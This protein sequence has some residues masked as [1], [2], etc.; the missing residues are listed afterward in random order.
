MAKPA[1]RGVH[2]TMT[3]A[4]DREEVHLSV[5][6]SDIVMG[7]GKNTNEDER[8]TMD[9]VRVRV[10]LQQA[11]RRINRKQVVRLVAVCLAL[12]CLGPSGIVFPTPLL[13]PRHKVV[14]VPT[15]QSVTAMI[16]SL[17]RPRVVQGLSEMNDG[18]R[19]YL[20]RNWKR[21]TAT[22]SR[23]DVS[24]GFFPPQPAVVFVQTPEAVAEHADEHAN[25]KDAHLGVLSIDTLRGL[26]AVNNERADLWAIA[27]KSAE[28]LSAFLREFCWY[29]RTTLVAFGRATETVLAAAFPKDSK[30]RFPTFCTGLMFVAPELEENDKL[31]VSEGAT[32]PPAVVVNQRGSGA[33]EHLKE[34]FGTRLQET[35]LQVSVDSSEFVKVLDQLVQQKSDSV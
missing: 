21:P 22:R 25:K 11:L 15:Y 35:G 18:N 30:D 8:K 17:R 14:T 24:N 34:V 10:M 12:V 6:G 20:V 33:T 7:C 28:E 16:Y 32:V 2:R 27:P 13:A 23:D 29:R 26:S 31:E 1:N 5:L 4:V 19:N 3:S 9:C